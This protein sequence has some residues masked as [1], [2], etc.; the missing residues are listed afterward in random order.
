MG[1][2]AGPQPA[3][4]H[5]DVVATHIAA[6][7]T[8]KDSSRPG[9]LLNYG[10]RPPGRRST[11]GLPWRH[12]LITC[13]LTKLETA[14][15]QIRKTHPKLKP[16]D[17]ALI[18]TALTLSG[19]HALAIYE[20]EKYTWPD[21]YEKLTKA[22]VPQLKL[23]QEGI[24]STAPKR[25]SKTAPEEEPV[26][27]TVG[28]TPNLSAGEK[29]LE[30][31]NDLKAKL[32]DILQEGVEFAYAPTD[33]GWQWALDRANWNTVAGSEMS[34][35]IKIKTGFTEGA[36]GL[37]MG[38]GGPKKRASRAK[39]APIVESIADSEGEAEAIAAIDSE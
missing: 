39:P 32:S 12:H 35:R 31:R 5:I 6:C 9:K 33:I 13:Q 36:V 8:F 22:M 28:L 34:R 2:A 30:G 1:E 10:G 20:E 27:V 37:E 26:I 4:T 24:E 23:V 14:L 19:R 11:S 15:D 18:A 21:D 3:A 17:A 25:V 38:S 29:Q 16:A 7:F